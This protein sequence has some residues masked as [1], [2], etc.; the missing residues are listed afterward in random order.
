MKIK[1]TIFVVVLILFA[2]TG[3]CFPS[4]SSTTAKTTITETTAAETTAP[5]STAT[6]T[7]IPITTAPET[8]AQSALEKGEYIKYINPLS[9]SSDYTVEI[10]FNPDN[11]INSINAYIPTPSV[12]DS[13]KNVQLNGYTSGGVLNGDNLNNKYISYDKEDMSGSN[14]SMAENFSF[15][16]YEIVTDL[17][18][19]NILPYDKNSSIYKLY[20][21]DEFQIETNYFRP[22]TPAIIGGE[23]NVIKQ[24]R[25]IYD[26]VISNMSY[27]PQ[28]DLG[29]A[30]FA[31]ENKGGECD[32][33]SALFVAMARSI[34]IPAR[35]VLGLWAEP[36]YGNLHVW[37]EFYLQDIGWVP[38]DP[39]IGQGSNK[40]YYFGNLDNKRLIMSKCYNV[41]LEG[42]IA[43]FFQIGAFWWYGT[44]SGPEFNFKYTKN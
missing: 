21:K 31:Y 43:G 38:V 29:G 39:T 27:V 5:E 20:T 30:K 10:R 22:I 34:G 36:S 15:T 6:E 35:P 3:C 23:T 40:D 26:Y 2:L 9:Y 18:I 17:N 1:L 28:G 12:W 14:L 19:E 33:Y 41:N 44:G 25:A 11:V 37:A 32:E 24:A 42:K 7:T 8:T 16:C 4:G 13:Q